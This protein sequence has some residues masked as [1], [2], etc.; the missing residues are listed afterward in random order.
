M[1][2]LT[3]GQLAY[4]EAHISDDAIPNILA[5]VVVCSAL[6]FIAVSLRFYSRSLTHAG[7]GIDDWMIAF[8]FVRALAY[9]VGNCR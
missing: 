7:L 3:P 5:S 1:A 9:G 6:A 2:N 8:A 4:L